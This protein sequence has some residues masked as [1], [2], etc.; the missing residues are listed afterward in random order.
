M[1]LLGY[2]VA[3]T[4]TDIDEIRATFVDNI[5]DFLSSG[6]GRVLFCQGVWIRSTTEESRFTQRVAD[7]ERASASS[8]DRDAIFKV[9]HECQALANEFPWF[10]CRA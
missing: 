7:L 4:C 1:S 10:L 9:I 6:K 5:V 2:V 8:F 3:F